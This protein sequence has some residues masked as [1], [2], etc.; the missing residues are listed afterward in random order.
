MSHELLHILDPMV[1]R[2]TEAELRFGLADLSCGKLKWFRGLLN[3]PYSRAAHT[4]PTSFELPQCDCLPDVSHFTQV[5]VTDPCYWTAQAPYLYRFQGTAHSS[6]GSEIAI[7]HTVGFRGLDIRGTDFLTNRR[8]T[9]LRGVRIPNEA[10]VDLEQAR[11]NEIAVLVDDPSEEFL[12]AA[13]E[14]GVAVVANLEKEGNLTRQLLALAWQPAVLLV[15]AHQDACYVP[16]DLKC[17]WK[18]EDRF[19]A[20]ESLLTEDSPFHLVD[21]QPVERPADKL[22]HTDKPVIALRRGVEFADL[23]EARRACDRLQAELAPEFDLAGYFVS[24]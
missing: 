10:D 14:T 9:V 22:K 23:A 21:L 17:A 16:H 20:G 15:L 8:R 11:A 3:G 1:F 24:P 6:D 12:Q 13:S 4:L 18:Q 19:V 5:C 7:E 2:A